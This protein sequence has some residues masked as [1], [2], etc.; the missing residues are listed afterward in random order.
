MAEEEEEA[1]AA[2]SGSVAGLLRRTG[3]D[4]PVTSG[5]LIDELLGTHRDEYLGYEF[6]RESVGARGPSRTVA[7]HVEVAERCWDGGQITKFHT[8]HLVLALAIDPDVGWPM[9]R[10][11]TI[12][13]ILARWQPGPP[14][15][16]AWDLLSQQ[17]RDLAEEQPLLA[18]A[19][20]APPEWTADL[21]EPVTLLALSP[22]ADRVAV[23]AGGR[24]T[25]PGTGGPRAG[26][27]TWTGRSSPSARGGTV[28]PRELWP[29]SASWSR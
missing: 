13:T 3:S 18:A 28:N 23:L 9:L 4:G 24:C 6:T 8:G 17:G 16:L 19:F 25:R 1:F 27:T 10:S 5:V 26:S 2:R 15:K 21:P 22:A 7:D 12:A 29:R 11:G 14:D 20:G